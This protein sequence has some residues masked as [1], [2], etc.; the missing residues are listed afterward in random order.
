MTWTRTL[1]KISIVLGAKTPFQAGRSHPHYISAARFCGNRVQNRAFLGE[2]M[3]EA[4]IWDHLVDE[5]ALDLCFEVRR[6]H[7]TASVYWHAH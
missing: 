2:R 6:Y 3:M 5:V 7:A 4:R 1:P